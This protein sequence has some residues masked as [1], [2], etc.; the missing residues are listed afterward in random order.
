VVDGQPGAQCE[1]DRAGELVQHFIAD[2]PDQD[3]RR[4]D[5]VGCPA[6]AALHFVNPAT[7]KILGEL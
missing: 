6:C 7:G 1:Y 2:E 3:E 4:Y 5:S